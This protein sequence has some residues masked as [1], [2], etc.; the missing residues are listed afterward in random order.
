MADGTGVNLFISDGMLQAIVGAM[1]MIGITGAGWVLTLAIRLTKL[2]TL[3]DT[4]GEDIKTMDSDIGLNRRSTQQI[5][6]ALDRKIQEETESLREAM[7][8]MRDRFEEIKDE[9]PSRSFIE[10]QLNQITGRIDRMIDVKL[11][12]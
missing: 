3:L 8:Q 12:K 6:S 1:A 5:G 7:N 11:A 9:L 2:E 4:F 10:Y